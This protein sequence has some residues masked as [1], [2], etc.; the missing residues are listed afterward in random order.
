ML[1]A[2]ADLSSLEN[3][4]KFNLQLPYD[5]E[6][7]FSQMSDDFDPHLAIAQGGGLL[8]EQE[9]WFYKIVKEGFPRENYPKCSKL[10]DMLN[11]TE[12]EKTEM[13]KVI[14]KA[15]GK[16]KNSN[17]ALQYSCGIKT[18][19][20]TAGVSETVAKSISKAYKSMNWSIDKIASDQVIKKTSHGT[21]QLNPFNGVWYHLKTDKDRFSTLVQG[22]GSYILDLWLGFQFNL[23]N[24][25]KYGIDGY[26]VRL[27]ATAHDEQIVE[28]KED[29]KESV[30]TLIEDSLGKVN[31]RFKLEIP[32][33]CDVQFGTKYSQ[34]H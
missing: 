10:D 20:R 9:V 23:R 1:L 31:D 17:Y 3:R 19:A 24:N 34:I 30:K 7:V 14:S 29:F 22:T 15:R 27:L 25:S 16:G 4:I 12:V 8:T 26:G 18:L 21:Y 32:F 33:G 2:G 13:L 5:R 28:F 11:L 6:Y